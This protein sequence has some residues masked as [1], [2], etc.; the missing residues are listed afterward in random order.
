MGSE[1][2]F[3]LGVECTRNKPT[4]SSEWVYADA[5]MNKDTVAVG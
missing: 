3:N 4:W 2:D 5:L 1:C